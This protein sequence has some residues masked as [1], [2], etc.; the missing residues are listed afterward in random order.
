MPIV[1]VFISANTIGLIFFVFIF[2]YPVAFI[3]NKLYN[4]IKIKVTY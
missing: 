4:V 2:K 3:L 1:L